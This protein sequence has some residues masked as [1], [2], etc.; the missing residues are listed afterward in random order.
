MQLAS[1]SLLTSRSRLHTQ[2]LIRLIRNLRTKRAILLPNLRQPSMRVSNQPQAMASLVHMAA[3][4]SLHL[5]RAQRRTHTAMRC[6]S[7]V[8]RNRPTGLEARSRTRRFAT[9]SSKRFAVVA[10][11]ILLHSFAALINRYVHLV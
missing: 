10:R 7:W 3:C 8:H 6:P 1:H 4:I 2:Q 9:P 11:L 5:V